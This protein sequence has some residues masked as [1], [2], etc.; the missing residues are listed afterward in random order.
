ME[1][2]NQSYAGLKQAFL[3][4]TLQKCCNPILSNE[5]FYGCTINLRNAIYINVSTLL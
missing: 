3:I 2:N 1:K 4:H 5:M